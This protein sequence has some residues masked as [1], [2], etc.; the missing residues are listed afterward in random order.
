MR[1][2]TQIAVNNCKCMHKPSTCCTV[3]TRYTKGHLLLSL[4]PIMQLAVDTDFSCSDINHS[5]LLVLIRGA[6]QV[7]RL[8]LHG[9]KCFQY[10]LLLLEQASYICNGVVKADFFVAQIFINTSHI[11]CNFEMADTP[12]Q[13]VFIEFCIRLSKSASEIC[14]ILK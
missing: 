9:S 12:E 3:K 11:I 8:M 14:E 1:K 2:I 10:Q 4:L 7:S 5:L 6:M 13:R